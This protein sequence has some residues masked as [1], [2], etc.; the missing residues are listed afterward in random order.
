M[1][2]LHSDELNLRRD[3]ELEMQFLIFYGYQTQRE[4]QEKWQIVDIPKCQ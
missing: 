2:R 1:F 4:D 3:M